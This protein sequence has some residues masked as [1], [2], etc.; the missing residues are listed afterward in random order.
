MI[1]LSF[2]LGYCSLGNNTFID[3]IEEANKFEYKAQIIDGYNN[4]LFSQ[5]DYNYLKK[6]MPNMKNINIIG[7]WSH[8]GFFDFDDEESYQKACEDLKKIAQICNLFKIKNIII[9]GINASGD[10]NHYQEIVLEK[11]RGFARSVEK[12]GV[13]LIIYAHNDSYTS[14]AG[15]MMNVIKENP[16]IYKALFDA[17]RHMQCGEVPMASYRH[18]KGNIKIF[19]ASDVDKYLLPTIIGTGETNVSNIIRML[20]KDKFDGYLC[21]N[22]NIVHYHDRREF[23]NKIKIPFYNLLIINKNEYKSIK[24]IDKILKKKKNDDVSIEDIKKVQNIAFKKI[25][26]KA[27]RN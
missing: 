23:L 25:I 22:P 11:Y 13:N 4:E 9:N 15:K 21:I 20:H 1:F 8:V 26:E 3:Y 19:I 14:D 2:K 12:L 27:E 7:Y 24:N 5:L 18:L 6:N 10:I 17:S 16:N